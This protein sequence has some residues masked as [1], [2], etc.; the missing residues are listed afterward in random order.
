MTAQNDPY[1]R[2]YYSIVEDE[3]F[4]GVYDDDRALATWLKLLMGADAMY[5]A[6]ATLPLG[7]HMPSVKKLADKGII[8]LVG[9]R[10]KVHGLEAEREVRSRKAS[11]SAQLRWS[12]PKA[13][14]GKR[15]SRST[16]FKVLQRDGFTCFYCGRRAPDVV[17]DVD[18]KVP[19]REG[20][21]DD[22]DNLVAACVDCNTGKSGHALEDARASDS[23]MRAHTPM[24]SASMLSSPL[25][26]SPLLSNPNQAAPSRATDQR[27]GLPHI[28][29]VS[30]SVAESIT[31]MGILTAGEKQLT[32]WDRLVEFHG[33]AKV[34]EAFRRVAKGKR[35][36]YRQLV[37]DT[38]KDLE[39]FAK[40]T[41]IEGAKKDEASD[42]DWEAR[43]AATRRETDWIRRHMYP[44]ETDDAA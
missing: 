38:V 21:T 26:S 19:F 43:V 41:V 37:W 6:P 16:R 5:P 9:S 4:V 14:G 1:V 29:E 32:E 34:A 30:Q 11:A 27:Y 15:P 22:M 33:E 28:T 10:Y 35:V 8:D 3:K 39:P 23:D 13:D 18:H 12:R 20:G 31:G 17:L 25:L 7:I 36:T 42:A 24:S 2:V 44:E 40:P